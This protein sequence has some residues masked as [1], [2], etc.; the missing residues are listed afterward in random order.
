MGDPPHPGAGAS[1][2]EVR[3]RDLTHRRAVVVV[4]LAT[5]QHALAAGTLVAT[6][7]Q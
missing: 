7:E 6:A 3:M 5:G 4:G 2:W 1:S